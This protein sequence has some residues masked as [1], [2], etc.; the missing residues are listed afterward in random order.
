MYRCITPRSAPAQ[1]VDESAGS[2]PKELGTIHIPAICTYLVLDLRVDDKVWPKAE[3]PL[4]AQRPFSGGAAG[5]RTRHKNH[6]D[7]RKHLT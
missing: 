5:N 6:A 2:F 7:L 3:G 1:K 4:I